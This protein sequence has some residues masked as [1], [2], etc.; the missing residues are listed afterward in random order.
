MEPGEVASTT[1]G[2]K[3]RWP[4]PGQRRHQSGSAKPLTDFARPAAR[5]S[6]LLLAARDVQRVRRGNR[7]G[8]ESGALFLAAQDVERMFQVSRVL[9]V[10]LDPAAIGGVREGQAHRV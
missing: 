8:M 10:E 1:A 7:T 6:G 3:P 5:H 2:A 9:A 4:V